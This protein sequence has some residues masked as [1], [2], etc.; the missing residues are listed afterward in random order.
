MIADSNEHRNNWPVGKIEAVY[1]GKDG[2]V[3]VVDVIT[4]KGIY[5]RPAV[6]ICKLD[7]RSK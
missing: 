1:P 7:I 3:R 4:S 2:L 5:R 6:K